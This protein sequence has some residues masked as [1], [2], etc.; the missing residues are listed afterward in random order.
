[1]YT[2]Q[3]TLTAKAGTKIILTKQD[4]TNYI[5]IQNGKEVESVTIGLTTSTSAESTTITIKSKT[6]AYSNAVISCEYAAIPNWSNQDKSQCNICFNLT[7]TGSYWSIT[8]E[9]SQ[10]DNLS[11]FSTNHPMTQ[12]VEVQIPTLKN[13]Q[14]EASP[15]PVL[16]PNMVFLLDTVGDNLFFRGNAPLG[17][18]KEGD[19]NQNIDFPKFVAALDSALHKAKGL[20]LPDSGYEICIIALLSQGGEDGI[21]IPEIESFGGT[22]AQ[23]SEDWYPSAQNVAYSI[24]S[25][26]NVTGRMCQWNINPAG[27]K[28][29]IYVKMAQQLAVKMNIWINNG[30]GNIDANNTKRIFY[31]HCASGHDRTGMMSASY[32]AQKKVSLNDFSN[33]ESFTDT[34]LTETYIMGTTLNKIPYSGGQYKPNCYDIN[35]HNIENPYKSRCFLISGAYDQTVSWVAEQLSGNP[36]SK[37]SLSEDALSG[38]PKYKYTNDKAYVE[39]AY[40]WTNSQTIMILTQGSNPGYVVIEY[41]EN[42]IEANNGNFLMSF[43]TLPVSLRP[44]KLEFRHINGV[45]KRKIIMNFTQGCSKSLSHTTENL[46]NQIVANNGEFVMTFSLNAP[47]EIQLST[48]EFQFES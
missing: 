36:S 24:P 10:G 46:S 45:N 20:H 8:G 23:L 47:P 37:L 43:C 12:T 35:N 29:G 48:I 31:I 16:D 19:P 25:L 41:L 30:I 27:T 42:Q 2:Q 3:Y 34:D 14:T 11:I 6:S 28:N 7:D 40:P 4:D 18:Q 15:Q 32:L 5:I 26:T 13:S 17:A 38:D 1:M 22:K 9:T 33:G 39:T 44:T 21:L